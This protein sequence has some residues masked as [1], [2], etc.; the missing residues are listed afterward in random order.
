MTNPQLALS[1]AAALLA[2]TALL[3]MFLPGPAPVDLVLLVVVFAGVSRGPVAALWTGTVAGLL[4]DAL[5]GGIFG[6]S[7]LA[8]CLTGALVGLSGTRLVMATVVSRFVAYTA[9]TL[10]HAICFFG[11]YMLIDVGMPAVSWSFLLSQA[12]VNGLVGAAA[13]LL[14]RAAPTVFRRPQLDTPLAARRWASE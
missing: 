5:S 7:G 9:A 12:A 1:L 2:Q 14:A 10:L 4:Q 3:R 11:V 13:L 6:V 8:K